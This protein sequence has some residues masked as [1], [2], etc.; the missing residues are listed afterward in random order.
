MNQESKGLTYK[1]YLCQLAK[2]SFDHNV[3]VFRRSVL[4]EFL[5]GISSCKLEMLVWACIVF[6]ILLSDD[7]GSDMVLVLAGE[8]L[9]SL[10]FATVV[11]LVP[12][13]EDT[14]L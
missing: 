8:D 14:W 3:Y 7:A 1:A 6:L 2:N 9:A 4:E 13:C 11:W 5:L 10:P 12:L